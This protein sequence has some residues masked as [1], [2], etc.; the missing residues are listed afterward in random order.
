MKIVIADGGHAADYII[1]T[2]KKRTNKLI[3]INSHKPTVQYLIHSNNLPVIYGEPFK[4]EILKEAHIDD[5][6]LFISLG[7]KDPDNYV[8]CL[9]AK[10]MFKAKKCICT[11]ANPKNVE[12]F[13]NLGIDSVISSTH[14]LATSIINESSLEDFNKSMAFEDDQIVLTEVVIKETYSV[15]NKQLMDIKFPKTGT[16]SCVYRKPNVIIP[17]GQT[18]LLAGDKLFVVSAPKDKK[19]LVNFLQKEKD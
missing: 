15:C 1:K 6:D 12:I 3:I 13:R 2:F 17:N 19:T 7:F 16:I 10:R 11:V 9:L 18:I 8:A 14:L 4:P 5:C